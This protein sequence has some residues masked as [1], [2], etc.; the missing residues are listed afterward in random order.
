MH[1]ILFIALAIGLPF[2]AAAQPSP[3]TLWTRTYGGSAHDRAYSVQQTADGGYIVA[4]DTWSFGA[5]RLD[6]YLVK[7]N[8]QGDTLWMNTYGG[9][10][11]DYGYSVQ[12]TADGGYVA[13]GSTVSFGSG[14]A[15]F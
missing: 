14:D 7:T 11:R 6:L 8:S 13:A 3:D 2:L 4:G 15:D 1:R 5:G 12:Q 10:D 9:T